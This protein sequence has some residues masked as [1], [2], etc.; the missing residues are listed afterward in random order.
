MAAGDCSYTNSASTSINL[1]AT[2]YQL[3]RPGPQGIYG[4]T[5]EVVVADIPRKIPVGVFQANNV[6]KRGII[7]PILV[8]GSTASALTTLIRTL[9]SA[10]WVDV[11]GDAQGLLT[12]TAP[13]SVVRYIKC[14]LSEGAE[15]SD[16]LGGGFSDKA[17]ARIDLPL[18][19]PDPTFYGATVTPTASAFNG[20]TNVNVACANAGDADAY[21]T[22]TYT[23]IVNNPKVT[24]AY[25]RFLKLEIVTTHAND[26]IQIVLD[27]QNLSML[28]TPN[29]GAATNA[30][31]YRSEDSSLIVCKY[32]TANLVFV[33][34]DAGDNATIGVSF[35]SRY[36]AHG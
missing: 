16:W 36:S 24:D 4:I 32:G 19:C 20:T 18:I 12:Y 1:N 27:P 13:N 3:Q 26:V 30:F 8:V 29:G 2:D 10:L 21:P 9:V 35:T 25:G 33:G 34:E 7:V 17:A 28:Y 11:R 23:G 6:L 14:S 22:I 5:P 31:G 15:V